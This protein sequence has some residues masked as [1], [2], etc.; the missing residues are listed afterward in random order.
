[1][2][3]IKCFNKEVGTMSRGIEEVFMIQ[4]NHQIL[5]KRSHL[6]R[7]TLIICDSKEEKDQVLTDQQEKQLLNTAACPPP[8]PE[9]R[10]R[11]IEV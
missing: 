3:S 9:T 7:P 8:R 11:L 10:G 6:V 2:E 1:M 5:L 4:K